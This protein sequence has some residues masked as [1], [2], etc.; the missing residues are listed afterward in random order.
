HRWRSSGATLS[1]AVNRLSRPPSRESGISSWAEIGFIMTMAPSMSACTRPTGAR[2]RNWI[3]ASCSARSSSKSSTHG[4]GDVADGGSAL[5]LDQHVA[6]V[7][8]RAG[9]QAQGYLDRAHAQGQDII[10]GVVEGA[11]AVHRVFETLGHHEVVQAGRH[12]GEQ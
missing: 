5:A 6:V 4:P 10:D 8:G 1:S 7:A 9:Q 12:I 2:Y 3:R 11:G